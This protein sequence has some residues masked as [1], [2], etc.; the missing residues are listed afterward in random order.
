MTVFLS[1]VL[2]IFSILKIILF[3]KIWG[4]TNNVK[5]ITRRIG[6]PYNKEELLYEEF[7]SKYLFLIIQQRRGASKGI[8]VRSNVA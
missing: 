6:F 5:N 4:M 3:F 2:L 7:Y 8:L 1:V